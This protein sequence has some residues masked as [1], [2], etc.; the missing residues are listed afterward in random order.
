[1]KYVCCN[2][3]LYTFAFAA[4]LLTACGKDVYSGDG[5]PAASGRVSSITTDFP[6]VVMVLSPAGAL[7]TGIIVG[8][9]AVIT[10]AHCLL[11]NGRY[12]IRTDRGD[13]STS[14]RDSNGPGTVDDPRDIGML[15]FDADVTDNDN[16]IHTFASSVNQGDN[17]TLVG[18]GCTNPDTRRGAGTKREAHNVI[19]EKNSDF[20][21]LLTAAST[22]R[23]IIGDENQGGTCFGDSGG[24]LFVERNG[25]QQLVGITHAGGKL[26]ALMVSE[27][28]NVADRTDNRSFLSDI[29]ARYGLGIGGI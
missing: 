29:N 8:R 5:L 12:T 27:F 1:M 4:L 25:K 21:V 10:A 23:M 17:V 20:L 19:A 11:S 24:P 15:R 6:G 2:S 9:R 28:V 7:C 16:D 18:F 14:D 3:L 13:F 22:V 26:G